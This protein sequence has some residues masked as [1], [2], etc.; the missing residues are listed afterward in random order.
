MYNMVYK[1]TMVLGQIRKRICLV[2]LSCLVCVLFL[3]AGTPQTVIFWN[4]ENLFDL[5]A[6]SL[7]R[8]TEFTPEGNRRWTPSRY[9]RKLDDLSRTLSAVCEETDEWPVAVGFAEVESDTVLRDLTLRSPLRAAGYRYVMTSGP[10]LRGINVGLLYRP[11]EITLLDSR[12]VRIPSEENGFSPTRDILH[13]T[14]RL[15]SGDTLHFFVVHLPSQLGA[16]R[17]KKQHRRLAVRTLVQEVM[18]VNG[19]PVLVMGDFNAGPRD[20]VFRL[21]GPV[22]HTLMPTDRR[23]LRRPEGTYVYQGEWEYLDHILVNGA[24]QEHVDKAEARAVRYP[25][26]LDEKGRPR[27]TYRGPS[28][29]G[30]ISDHLPVCAR[31]WWRP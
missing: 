19:A 5:Y 10:D 7:S 18:K 22:L 21:L 26:L 15:V 9:W 14:G 17:T 29:A 27:R 24:L 12:A 6:D 25:F 13:V 4:V 23:A 30:G 31:L 3:R 2:I 8:D 11:K 28:Y 20:E 1:K 16:S